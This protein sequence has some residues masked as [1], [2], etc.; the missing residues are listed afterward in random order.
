MID[1]ATHPVLRVR[2]DTASVGD[3]DA[4]ALSHLPNA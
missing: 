4:T 2:S 3:E 1:M